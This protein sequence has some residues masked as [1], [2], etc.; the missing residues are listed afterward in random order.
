MDNEAL[1]ETLIEGTN[2]LI[3]SVNPDRS[4]EFTNKSWLKA[5]GYSLEEV[6]DLKLENIIFPEVL[7]EHKSMLAS[8][9]EGI[10]TT[11]FETVFIAKDGSRVYVE[12]NVFP[13]YKDDKVVA[14]QGFW[15]DVTEK[16]EAEMKLIEE[17]KRADFLLDLMIHDVTNINQEIISTLELLTND[18]SLPPHLRD[19]VEEGVKEVERAS[20]LVANVR[21]ISIVQTS[22]HEM[23]NQDLGESLFVASKAVDVTFPEK[24]LKLNTNLEKGKFFIMADE[25]LD[26]VFKSLLHNSMKFDKKTE[27]EVDVIAEPIK[28]TPFLKLEIK[29]RGPGIADEH[30]EEVFARVADRREGILGLGLGLTLVKKILENYGGQIRVEDRVEGDHTK[31]ANFVILIRYEETPRN[32]GGN[33]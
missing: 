30:K 21:K 13:R 18:P 22:D 31:G 11:K 16:K 9:L 24:K 3:H 19:F 26:D 25:Y 12:G 14:A 1:Y 7:E 6:A 29:D 28:H 5:L 17:R 8:V 23:T 33:N 20:N 15:R 27:V 32:P 2:D 4:F 10:A